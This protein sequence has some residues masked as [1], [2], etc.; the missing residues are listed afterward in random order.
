M[1]GGGRRAFLTIGLQPFV[2]RR[3]IPGDVHAAFV[4]SL[5]VSE[6]LWARRQV[7]FRALGTLTAS[8]RVP[9]VLTRRTAVP[10]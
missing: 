3:V 2:D 10:R 7:D 8:P 1:N 5:V 9:T 6:P 4:V